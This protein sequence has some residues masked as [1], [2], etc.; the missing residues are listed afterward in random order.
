[1]GRPPSQFP[2]RG[3]GLER[4]MAG[5][6]TESGVE[7]SARRGLFL[8]RGGEQRPV[9][10]VWQAAGRSSAGMRCRHG[11]DALGTRDSHD[12]LQRRCQGYGQR[13]VFHTADRRR[14]HV[15]HRCRGPLA[16]HREEVRQAALDAAALAGVQ[17]HAPDVRLF[18]QPDRV[19]R[20]RD[21]PGRR[22]GQGGDGIHGSTTAASPGR[23]TISAMPTLRRC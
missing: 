10:D 11:Q 6:R 23:A 17:G 21:C 22:T 7:A 12:I 8:A 1:M 3:G 16:M 5:Q 13:T 2:D 14:P 19:S 20:H 4:S 9:H 15:H 18:V